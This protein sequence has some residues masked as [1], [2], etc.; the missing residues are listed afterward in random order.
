MGIA[1]Q[2]RDAIIAAD[3]ISR[4]EANRR[5]W[6]IDREGLLY[7][8]EAQGETRGDGKHEW[9]KAKE[10]FVKRAIGAKAFFTEVTKKTEEIRVDAHL[11]VEA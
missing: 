10:E 3:G 9:S 11:G 1:V 2:V 4:E 7:H 8:R 5:F 6:L